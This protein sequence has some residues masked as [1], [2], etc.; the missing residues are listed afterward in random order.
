MIAL[1][2]ALVDIKSYVL[3][4]SSAGT[5]NIVMDQ[6]ILSYKSCLLLPI[7][8]GHIYI[9]IYIYI[10]ISRNIHSVFHFM[11]LLQLTSNTNISLLW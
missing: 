3:L 1:A 10:Y 8:Y 5:F 7:F 6:Y 11:F 4:V 9:Y 2:F